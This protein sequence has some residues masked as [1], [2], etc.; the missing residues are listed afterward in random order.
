[1]FLDTAG[2]LRDLVSSHQ[3]LLSDSQGLGIDLNSPM[4][5]C[6]RVQI[7]VCP[8]SPLVFSHTLLGRLRTGYLVASLYELHVYSFTRSESGVLSEYGIVAK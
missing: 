4:R 6:T 2:R 1:M 7:P 8:E 5:I 3:E